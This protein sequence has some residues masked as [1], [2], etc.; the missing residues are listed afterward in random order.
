VRSAGLVL[1]T[2]SSSSA[3]L[4][5]QASV[6]ALGQRGAKLAVSGLEGTPDGPWA[7]WGALHSDASR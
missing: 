1:R 7:V 4:T 3:E 5:V 2:S 6:E